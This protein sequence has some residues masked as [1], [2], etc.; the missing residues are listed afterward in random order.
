MSNSQFARQDIFLPEGLVGCPEW[1]RFQLEPDPA[2][3]P[4]LIL[5]SLDLEGLS[6]IV[7]DPRDLLPDYSYE[8]SASDLAALEVTNPGSLS[9]LIILNIQAEPF[10]ITANLL[11]PLLLNPATGRARQVIQSSHNYSAAHVL[12]DLTAPEV[13]HAGADAPR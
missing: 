5:R 10:R 1:R 12:L 8:A 9:P 6:F 2:A 4:A 3:A 7:T 11:G 13:Q